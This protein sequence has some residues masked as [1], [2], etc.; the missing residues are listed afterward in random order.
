MLAALQNLH[1]LCQSCTGFGPVEKSS[2]K[3]VREQFG[4]SYRYRPQRDTHTLDPCS[5]EGSGQTHHPISCHSAA[6]LGVQPEVTK[7]QGSDGS[8]EHNRLCKVMNL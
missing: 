6:G 8:V 3:S 5:Q 1:G 4:G 2:V 7:S